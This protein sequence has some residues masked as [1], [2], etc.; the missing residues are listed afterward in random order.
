MRFAMTGIAPLIMHNV[1]TADPMNV[2]AKAMKK[3]HDKKRNKTD[4][5]E[6]E[7]ARLKFVAGLY[8]DEKT[9]PFLPAANLF[10][11]LIEAGTMT[12]NGKNIERGVLILSGD[13]AR[14]E[15]DG[16]RDVDSLYGDGETRFVDRRIG[17]IQRQRVVITRPIFPEWSAEFEVEVDPEVLNEDTFA[18]IAARAGKAIGV[19]DYRRFY[20]KFRVDLS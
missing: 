11:C 3:I 1:Q 17:V 14:L 12:R 20:G 5:D 19:G 2:Y 10:R 8:Y 16:P 13:K 9:G 6:A 15:Y 4:A 18:D 7:L